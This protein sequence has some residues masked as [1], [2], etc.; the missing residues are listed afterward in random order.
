MIVFDTAS[1]I[2]IGLQDLDLDSPELVLG[3]TRL[4][5]ERQDR[6]SQELSENEIALK[7]DI[8]LY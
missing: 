3:L 4:V 5:F 2:Q 7:R 6:E 1:T 8:D